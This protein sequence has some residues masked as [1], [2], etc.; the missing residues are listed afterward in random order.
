MYAPS[1]TFCKFSR[2][3]TPL[4][5]GSFLYFC[6][7]KFVKGSGGIKNPFYYYTKQRM[8]DD[9]NQL[10]QLLHLLY[11]FLYLFLLYIFLFSVKRFPNKLAPNVPNNI[12]RNP[13]FC[14]FTSFLILHYFTSFFYFMSSISSF[15]I[16]SVVFPDPNIFLCI[17]AS[18]STFGR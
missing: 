16:I 7:S 9:H 3:K 1:F 14:S 13:P 5:L 18:A 8:K 17:P 15:D 11:L 2:E 4:N 6:N 10:L 12:L